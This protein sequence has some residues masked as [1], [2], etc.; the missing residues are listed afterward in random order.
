MRRLVV[1]L[2]SEGR[3]EVLGSQPYDVAK[4]GPSGILEIHPR[5]TGY[6]VPL[7]QPI[8]DWSKLGISD[9]CPARGGRFQVLCAVHASGATS[10]FTRS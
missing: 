4:V 3:R 9:M 10:P 7:A 6:F 8:S 5:T 1:M 2:T